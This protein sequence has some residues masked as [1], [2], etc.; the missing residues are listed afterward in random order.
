MF[1][2]T[3]AAPSTSATDDRALDGRV[4]VLG[5]GQVSHHIVAELHSRGVRPTVVSRSGTELDDADATTADANDPTA[6]TAALDGASLVISTAQPAYHRW[7]EEFP[8]LQRSIVEACAA[9]DARLVV[10]DNVYAYGTPGTPMTET[11]PFSATDRKGRTRAAMATE[12]LEAHRAG[13]VWT[14]AVRASDFIGPHARLTAYG[15]RFVEP[16]LVGKAAEVLGDP[17]RLHSVAFLPDVAQALVT[18]GLSDAAGGRAWHAPH[19][20]AV[21]QRQL[22]ELVADAAGSGAKLRRMR[23]WQ[24]SLVGRFLPAAGEVAEMW[25]EFMT[26]HVVDD[27]AIRDAFGLDATPLERVAA[28]TVAWFRGAVRS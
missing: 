25:H 28:A 4:V 2:A 3:H 5:A 11:T 22:V 19:A 24:L 23:R 8:A 1:D 12:L 16:L 17:D 6:L 20:P 27:S 21:S 14:T 7:P 9:N 15:E 13:H 18:V 10:L 26:D